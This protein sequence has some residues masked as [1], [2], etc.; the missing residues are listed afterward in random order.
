MYRKKKELFWLKLSQIW[1][2]SSRWVSK[3]ILCTQCFTLVSYQSYLLLSE[4]VVHTR[5]GKVKYTLPLTAYIHYLLSQKKNSLQRPWLTAQKSKCCTILKFTF[6]WFF[7]IFSI[8]NVSNI[9]QTSKQYNS[10]EALYIWYPG[11]PAPLLS[12]D[13]SKF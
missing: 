5:R 10:I 11:D 9:L 3:I 7:F 6:K 8:L 12:S 1:D 4:D 13:W 2:P